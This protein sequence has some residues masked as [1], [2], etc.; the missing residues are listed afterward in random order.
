MTTMM[1]NGWPYLNIHWTYNSHPKTFISTV[2]VKWTSS[3][4]LGSAVAALQAKGRFRSVADIIKNDL[5]EEQK[6]KL[7]CA[8]KEILA[9]NIKSEDI[10]T[11]LIFLASHA[12]VKTLLIKEIGSFLL[13]EIHVRM[14]MWHHGVSHSSRAGQRKVPF[15]GRYHKNDLTKNSNINLTL[16]QRES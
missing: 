4:T 7:N 13:N 15:S 12:D 5:T 10:T 8:A 11:L 9:G 3:G 1:S 2:D 14:M 16:R 6:G